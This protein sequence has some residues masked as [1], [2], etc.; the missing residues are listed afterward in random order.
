MN[1]HDEQAALVSWLHHAYPFVLFHS[2]PNGA[3]LAGGV[4]QRVAKVNILKA[5]GLL[6]GTADL[7]IA[8]PRGQYHGCYVEMKRKTG[9]ALSE[10]QQWFLSEAETAGYYTIVAHG[11]EQAR[12]MVENYL[13]W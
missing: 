5:E 7:F 3:H 2:I 10:N 12:E 1:E 6:P 4:G 11:F 9:G 8:A 13:S